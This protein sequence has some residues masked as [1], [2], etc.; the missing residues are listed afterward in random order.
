M[1][2]PFL[3][4]IGNKMAILYAVQPYF[5]EE[6]KDRYHLPHNCLYSAAVCSQRKL[7]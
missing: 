4:D 3:F 6:F 2:A 7:L 5:Y 1:A